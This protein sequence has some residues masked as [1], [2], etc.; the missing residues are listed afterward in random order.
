LD[1][2]GQLRGICGVPDLDV[3]VE[4]DPVG[5]V[6]DL[7]LKLDSTRLAQ[8]FFADRAAIDIAQAER[9][10]LRISSIS[11]NIRRALKRPHRAGSAATSRCSTTES[12]RR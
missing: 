1:R 5:V 8:T 6:D 12:Q 2:R 3:V 9:S 7:G 10:S 4:D 11:A